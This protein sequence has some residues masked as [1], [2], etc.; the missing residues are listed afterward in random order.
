MRGADLYVDA[1]LGT[2]LSKSLREPILGLVQFLNEM[3][4][5]VVALD[6]PTGLH[7]DTGVVLGAAVKAQLTV[8]MGALKQ[9]LLIGCG[10][11]HTGR[12]EVVDI[13]VPGWILDDV[14][15]KHSAVYLTDDVAVKAQLPVRPRTAHKYS[16][17][18][19]L[20]VG[21]SRHYVGAP[22]MASLAAARVGAGYVTCATSYE[23]QPIVAA[24]MI[25][26]VTVGL[27][28]V[29][30]GGLDPEGGGV[31][32]EPHVTKCD[33]LL[34]GP[35]LGRE[36]GTRHFILKL[37][38]RTPVPTVVDADG[39]D[40]VG[41]VP[42]YI[43]RHA[44][45]RWILTPHE[46]EFRRLV[47][48]DMTDRVRVARRAAQGWNCV[49]VLKGMPTLVAW[50]AGTV[51]ICATGGRALATAGTGDIL[52]GLCVGLLAQ[53]L[54]PKWA[55]VCA[56][57]LG[58]A[59]ADRWAKRRAPSSMVATDMLAELPHAIAERFQ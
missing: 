6:V 9:G 5:P 34:V 17:G 18:T 22:V 48:M 8:T 20:V 58:G 36:N 12:T 37:L 33:A 50:P 3:V 35:G 47:D 44:Q 27:P 39:L 28:M 29:A 2:G 38:E 14:Q 21:G 31:V 19:A 32:L 41:T 10:P 15:Q 54:S 53:G 49:L 11:D 25:E 16:A 45:G 4:R 30:G 56:V 43:A 57:H 1:L 7:A 59:A 42:G 40:A 13:G 51:C 23:A 26:T 24:K 52:A 46:G 55:A